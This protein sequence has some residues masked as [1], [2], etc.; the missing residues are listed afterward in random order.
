MNDNCD[1]CMRAAIITV[2]ETETT[3]GLVDSRP[4]S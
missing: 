3:V 4:N 1:G 2:I